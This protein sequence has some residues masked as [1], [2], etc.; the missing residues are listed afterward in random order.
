[1]CLASFGF[2]G[3]RRFAPA[4]LDCVSGGTFLSDLHR[5][6]GKDSNAWNLFIKL[7]LN[8]IKSTLQR[9]ERY[10]RNRFPKAYLMTKSDPRTSSSVRAKKAQHPILLETIPKPRET[11]NTMEPLKKH[12]IQGFSCEIRTAGRVTFCREFKHQPRPIEYDKDV[13]QAQACGDV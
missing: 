12:T 13:L 2:N 4:S 8:F 1:M 11:G 7:H 9:L 6:S 5:F 3:C 10:L